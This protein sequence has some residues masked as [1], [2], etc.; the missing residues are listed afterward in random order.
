M[1]VALAVSC[2]L[3]LAGSGPAAVAEPSSR[4]T[5]APAAVPIYTKKRP[6]RAPKQLPRR[7]SVSKDGITWT[8]ARPAQVGR[9][10]TGDPYVVGPV[11][12]TAISPAPS[13]G[14]N[15]SVK[16]VPAEDDDSGFDSRTDGNR[17]ESRLSVR[18]PVGIAPGDSLVSSISVDR[19]GA[20]K[21]WLF[22]KST[23]SPVRSISILTSVRRPLPRDAFR[24]SYAG[25]S[26][27][28][29]SR[30]LKRHL[31]PR[32]R[33]VAETPSLA[34]YEQHFRRPWVDNLLFNFDTPIDY[35]PD[36][37]RE[38]SRAVGTAG[39][40]LSLNYAARQKEALLVYLT[41]YGIDLHGLKRR[42]HP[43]WPAH[44][45]H[46]SG[47]KFPIVFAGVML[48]DRA[49]QRV[50]GNFG[51]DMQT[52]RGN[53]W[54][55]AKALYAGH[56]GR[57]GEGKYGPYEHLQ[58]RDWPD[59]LGEDYRRC[60]TS[61]AWIGEALAARLVPGVRRA[62]AYEPF[63]E[64]ADRWMTEDDAGHLAAIR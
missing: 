7:T 4:T 58:P 48:G 9:F 30:N 52:I 8:F 15:G 12:I 33:R 59:S 61:G 42:G 60:C 41:Q 55:G 45:G 16:N 31:L 34:E 1:R 6:P 49:M 29:L 27:I 24:P 26:P 10:V 3:L 46:G 39:L 54:T 25:R 23:G 51:E 20:T 64:Y 32:L 56:Y 53:G 36:Y 57:R 43:G 35:M 47:R 13:N 63:F 5:A 21:R 22:D 28:Y 40:L 50:A 2:T 62:W 38:I 18:P 17:Y 37:S 19:V 14:R 44:G 11:T